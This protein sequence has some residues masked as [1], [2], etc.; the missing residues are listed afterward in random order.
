VAQLDPT[1]TE[2]DI[3]KHGYDIDPKMG[4]SGKIRYDPRQVDMPTIIGAV[5]SAG[6]AATVQAQSVESVGA[7]ADFGSEAKYWRTMLLGSVVFAL[8]VFVVSMVLRNCPPRLSGVFHRE[9]LPGLSL[10]VL[11]NGLL[12]APVYF[13]FGS[14]FHRNA[15]A[16]LRRCQFNMDVLVSL[17][18]TASFFYSIVSA[19]VSIATAGEESFDSEE[20]ETAAMLI[21]F[22]LLGKWLES[23]AK[24][25]ASQAISKLLTLVPPTALQLACSKEID[26]EPMEVPVASLRRGDVVKVL[27]GGQVP[28]DGTVLRGASA[29]NEA[30]I[31]GESLPQ[32]KRA[33][34]SVIGGTING[35]G[36]LYVLVTAVGAGSTLAQIMKVVAD[37][38]HRTHAVARTSR[39][40]AWYSN[41]MTSGVALTHVLQPSPLC[42]G[43]QAGDPSRRRPGLLRLRADRH[44]PRAAHVVGLDAGRRGGPPAVALVDARARAAQHVRPDARDAQ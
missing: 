8:P 18:T 21:T 38:Q 16:N 15:L 24:G 44:R 6:F 3:E 42:V 36:V 27:P 4:K 12:A 39:R 20:F 37:A 17:G 33:H 26:A 9:V 40:A 19:V 13:C 29:V 35:S 34:D 11:V 28:V 23:A 14:P 31:T 1:I 32:P 25:Q 5:H 41:L 43:R 2:K 7:A 22:I 10:G 30:M